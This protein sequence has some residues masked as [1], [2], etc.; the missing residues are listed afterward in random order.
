MSMRVIPRIL[1]GKGINI[2]WD[3]DF[4]TEPNEIEEL[5]DSSSHHIT[6]RSRPVKNK[7]KTVVLPV[8]E[9]G[10]FLEQIFIVLVG[11]QFSA[12]QN[13]SSRS[14]STSISTSRLTAL[15]LFHKVVDFFLSI[16]LEIFILRINLFKCKG[17]NKLPFII[18]TLMNLCIGNNH[19]LEIQ[20]RK[21]SID[22]F[23]THS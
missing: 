6:H 11:M 13:T 15:E 17:R 14:A 22:I 5:L 9:S 23:C 4:F 12:I 19:L 18:T 1:I 10:Y 8:R 20:N 2:E 3:I 7:H 16:T 21:F